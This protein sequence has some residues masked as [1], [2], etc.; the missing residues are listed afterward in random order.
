[1]NAPRTYRPQVGDRIR[2]TRSSPGGRVGVITGT[3]LEVYSY[4]YLIWDDATV[5]RRT[6]AST[7]FFEA[8]GDGWRQVIEPG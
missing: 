2:V 7:E 5:T 1:M 4:G 6:L 3:V 8:D